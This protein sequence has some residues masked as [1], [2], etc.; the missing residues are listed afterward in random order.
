MHSC[1]ESISALW[2]RFDVAIRLS[3]TQRF[4]QH[5]HGAVDIRFLDDRIAPHN[6]EQ[7]ILVDEVSRVFNRG[8]IGTG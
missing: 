5:R 6:L 8:V 4:P 3:L 2:N 7:L 1:H